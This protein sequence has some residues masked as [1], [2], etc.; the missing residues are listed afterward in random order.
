M[1]FFALRDF[2][3]A[4]FYNLLGNKLIHDKGLSQHMTL[5]ILVCTV[6]GVSELMRSDI[7]TREE[8][9]VIILIEQ[10]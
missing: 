4:H 5:F 2:G 3:L 9:A 6:A 1:T 10:P 8:N 7:N